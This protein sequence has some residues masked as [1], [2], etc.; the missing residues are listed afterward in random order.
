MKKRPKFNVKKCVYPDNSV[1]LSKLLDPYTARIAHFLYWIGFS[2]NMTTVLTFLLGLSGIAAMLLI[3]AYTGLVI[4]AILITLRNI[5]DTVDGKI[6][7]GSGTFTPIGG[8]ADL[9]SD[10]IIFHAAFFIAVGFLTNHVALGFLCVTGYMSREFAR[11]HFTKIYGIK[12]TETKTAKKMPF[13]VSLARKYDLSSAFW[14]I[15]I[16]LLINPLWIIYAI[17]VIEYTLLAGELGLDVI[18]LLRKRKQ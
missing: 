8:F 11:R 7:R 6:A 3:P 4:A 16:I 12:I 13:I 2:A 14:I 10:W 18:L 9:V 5:G 15:P 1:F 17:A